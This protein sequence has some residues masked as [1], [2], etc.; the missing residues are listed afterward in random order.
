[1]GGA[2]TL[3][4]AAVF[5]AAPATAGL[6]TPRARGIAPALVGA[7]AKAGATCG[8]RVANKVYRCTV[9]MEGAGG[10]FTDCFR[11]TSPGT[12]S[13]KFDLATDQLGTT[14]GCTCKAKG[15][16]A[17]PKF[18]TAPAFECTGDED[19]SFEGTVSG[20]GK[21]IGKGFAA[22]AAG[23]GFVFSCTLDPACSL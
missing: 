8:D 20:N 7:A 18:G 10:P 16:P 17:K 22:N 14:L 15:K 21:K 11:F 4:F 13:D 19:V 3:L 6:Y 1:M 2:L 5:A 23:V 12:V 9:T